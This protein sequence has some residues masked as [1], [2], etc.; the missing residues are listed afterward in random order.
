MGCTIQLSGLT[1]TGSVKIKVTLYGL[2]T[3]IPEKIT[4][5]TGIGEYLTLKD[6]KLCLKSNLTGNDRSIKINAGG[7]DYITDWK[8]N[9]KIQFKNEFAI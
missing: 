5:N 7:P 1:T 4:P 2:R 9:S 8:F 3:I 6:G